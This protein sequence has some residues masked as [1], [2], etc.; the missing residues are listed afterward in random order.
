ME[1]HKT[2]VMGKTATHI[3]VLRAGFRLFFLAAGVYA[4]LA[5]VPWAAAMSGYSGWPAPDTL[6][7]GHEMIFGFAAAAMAGFLLTAVPTWAGRGGLT[8]MPLAALGLVW[9]AGRLGWLFYPTDHPVALA[10]A[11]L[12]FLPALALAIGPALVS[13]RTPRNLIFLPVLAAYWTG[14]LLV[15]LDALDVPWADAGQGLRLGLGTLVLMIVLVGGRIVP[16]FTASALRRAAGKDPGLRFMPGLAA[17][18]IA[19]AIAWVLVSTLAPESGAAAGLAFALALVLF[20]RMSGWRTFATRREP[21]VWVLHLGYAWLIAG[22]ATA[23][24]A[25]LL[26]AVPYTAGL[27]AH[28]T[29]AVGTM[30]MAVMSRASLGHSGRAVRA[31]GP[32]ITA[33][34]LVS[35]AALSRIAAPFTDQ[36][37]VFF[38]LAGAFWTAA[39]AIFAITFLPILV[40]G[41]PDGRPG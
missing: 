24:L 31:S 14:N 11:D 19:L 40:Q 12:A 29:G 28:A 17:P 15:H 18:V 1:D 13:A 4:A 41:R 25:A 10:I 32:L 3:P 27:H 22:F 8:G 33:Y 20:L 26:P 38:G 39:F 2:N 30:V 36:P 37:G 35:A 23:G 7:H 16:S 21:I 6:W 9:A 5:M 34:L